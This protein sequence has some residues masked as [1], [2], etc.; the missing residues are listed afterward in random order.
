MSIGVNRTVG[1]PKAVLR[2]RLIP[3][4]HSFAPEF[5]VGAG[6]G[7]PFRRNRSG[8]LSNTP[9]QHVIGPDPWPLVATSGGFVRWVTTRV[10]FGW[11]FA[12][13]SPEAEPCGE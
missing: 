4:T 3:R 11:P 5:R 7:T 9:V 10:Q 1:N 6:T 8:T 12:G 13:A 2:K